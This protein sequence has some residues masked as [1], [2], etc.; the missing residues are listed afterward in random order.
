MNDETT[1]SLEDIAKAI[2]KDW[3]EAENRILKVGRWLLQAKELCPHGQFSDWV[4]AHCPFKYRQGAKYM[5]IA[6]EE[7]LLLAA[8]KGINAS[9]EA[10]R[11]ETKSDL[12]GHFSG[13]PSKPTLDWSKILTPEPPP[14][15]KV[16]DETCGKIIKYNEGSD[17][18]KLKELI[19]HRDQ[20]SQVLWETAKSAVKRS[21]ESLNTI[22]Q[23][24]ENG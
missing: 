6:K 9:I 14:A 22:L 4:E 19:K 20:Y 18:A 10:I 15:S 11:T 23:E 17:I 1:T 3:E 24:M 21:I 8:P 7:H 16:L 5:K 12:A 2:Q 13:S